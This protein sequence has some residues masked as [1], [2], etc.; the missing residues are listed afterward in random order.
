MFRSFIYVNTEKVYEYYSVLDESVKERII[1][2]E[3]S[4]TNKTG[5]SVKPIGF[6]RSKTEILKSDISQ[7]FLSDYNRFEKELE[8]LDGENY[9]DLIENYNNYDLTTISPASIVKIQNIF[10]IPEGFDYVELVSLFKPMLL[11]SLNIKENEQS[12]FDAFL[13][14]TKADI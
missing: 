7:Y 1:S 4:I 5:F 11:S 9:F 3:S 6:E 10:Y 12:L 13:S 2:R 8:K 14:N